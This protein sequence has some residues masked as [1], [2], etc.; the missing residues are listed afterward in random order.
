MV[1]SG[2]VPTNLMDLP[3]GTIVQPLG[4]V[5]RV[6]R[7]PKVNGLFMKKSIST[8]VNDNGMITFPFF[9]LVTVRA[10]D[11]C[12]AYLPVTHNGIDMFR[13]PST[14]LLT[15][16]SEAKICEI[17]PNIFHING[18]YYWQTPNYMPFVHDI[19]QVVPTQQDFKSIV[20]TLPYRFGEF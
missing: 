15:P 14:H 8:Y 6:T 1:A 4:S 11:Q 18:Y 5:L 12:Y 19:Y 7:C 16:S 9:I 3:K 2:T 20:D 10:A 17:E 13:V